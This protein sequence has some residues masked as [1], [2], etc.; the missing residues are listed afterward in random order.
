MCWK[1]KIFYLR[2]N[3]TLK[4][5]GCEDNNPFCMQPRTI[6]LTAID[7]FCGRTGCVPPRSSETVVGDLSGEEE[8]PTYSQVIAE[9]DVPPYGQIDGSVGDRGGDRVHVSLVEGFLNGRWDFEG[10]WAWVFR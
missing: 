5:R 7:G 6:T 8:L 3:H 4:E 2:C 1:K 10:L 9:D